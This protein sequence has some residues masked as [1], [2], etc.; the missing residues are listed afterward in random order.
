MEGSPFNP[1]TLLATADHPVCTLHKA[2]VEHYFSTPAWVKPTPLNVFFQLIKTVHTVK[3]RVSPA[4]HKSCI[5]SASEFM[6]HSSSP[7]ALDI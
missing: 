1:I 3:I 2:A 6:W 5:N 7:D 4:S